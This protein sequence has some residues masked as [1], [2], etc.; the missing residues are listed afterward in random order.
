MTP[1][2]HLPTAKVPTL[3]GNPTPVL[4]C[5]NSPSPQTFYF[6]LQLEIAAFAF[7]TYGYSQQAHVYISE[8]I[9]TD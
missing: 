5:F 4:K 6:P 1:Y 3:I 8:A 9:I 7:F 2:P